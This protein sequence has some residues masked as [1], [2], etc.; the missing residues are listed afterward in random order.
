MAIRRRSR[1][2]TGGQTFD[3]GAMGG[4]F[5][6]L[7]LTVLLL[8]AYSSA[9]STGLTF[10]PAYLGAQSSASNSTY[11]SNCATRTSIPVQPAFNTTTGKVAMRIVASAGMGPVC[12]HTCV[13]AQIFTGANLVSANFT[14]P[15]SGVHV[16]RADWRLAWHVSLVTSGSK[17]SSGCG[18]TSA[19]A[20]E[21]FGITFYL[22]DWT[23]GGSWTLNGGG[24]ANSSYLY[25]VNA[26]VGKN[27]F[28]NL[29]LPILAAVTR[30]DSYAFIASV[31]AQV[32]VIAGPSPDRALAVLDLGGV[33]A[34]SELT[35]VTL[36]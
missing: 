30:G 20:D 16:L 21:D 10:T 19:E 23:S 4:A 35:K 3:L 27:L 6:V 26:S 29:S 22:I 12:T 13:S 9:A 14:V 5:S 25:N 15:K 7:A 34:G 2:S 11:A 31:Q 33:G 1:S 24:Y 17:I 8:P 36:R 28:T 18:T 32:T